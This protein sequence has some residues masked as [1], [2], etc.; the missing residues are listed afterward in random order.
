MN[1]PPT[2][3]R[4]APRRNGSHPSACLIPLRSEPL[5]PPTGGP[6]KPA[7]ACSCP[8]CSLLHEG[9]SPRAPDPRAPLSARPE[10]AAARGRADHRR[11]GAGARRR[12][13]GQ[14]RGPD[15]PARPSRLHP[16]RLAVRDPR[17]HLHQQGGARDEGKGRPAGRRRGRGHALARHLPLRRGQD[18][19]AP[20]RAGRPS[21]QLHHPRHRRPAAPAQA[22]HLGRRHRRE[23]LAGAASRRPHRPLEES[24]LDPRPDRRRRERGLCQRQGRRAL[25]PL[26]GAAEAAQRLRLRRP[27]AA[28]AG[29]PQDATATS[30]PTIRRASNI[31]SSTNIRTPTR[32]SICGSGCSPRSA[33]TS[34]ASATTTRASIPGAAPRSPTSFA[35]RRTSPAPRSSGSS[36]I[37]ARPRTSSPPPR[38]S[39]PTMAAASARR[40]GPR[41]RRARRSG[42]SE[43]G[44]GPR[45]PGGSARRS[46]PSSAAAAASTTSPSWS[47]PSSRPASSRT[48]SSPSACPTG[49]S[50]VSD[51]TS[52]PRSA[53]PSPTCASSPSPPTT[54]P[55]SASSTP[56]SAASATRRWP[57]STASPAPRARRC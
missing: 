4:S 13:H 19:Q 22:A 2:A 8:L 48:A 17:R 37:T 30:S 5:L 55:S 49:S 36:R 45:R 7:M 10:P 27:A 54:S 52:A 21:V 20:R 42:S 29:H 47:A 23:T 43:S 46:R 53:T 24:R 35:S 12:G 1:G 57:R 51:S 9:D 34:A 50:A 11:T 33:R 32:A 18:A 44:T 14:D 40:C 31:S 3:S 15:R 16:A 56:P 6:R 25:R 26:P 28:H 41:R 38:A 39:S